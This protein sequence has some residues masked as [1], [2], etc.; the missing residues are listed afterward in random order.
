MS[1]SRQTSN[2]KKGTN[3]AKN[4]ASDIDAQY[5]FQINQWLFEPLG[6]WPHART[7]IIDKMFRAMRIFACLFL[8]AFVT[9]PGFFLFLQVRG[10]AALTGPFILYVM[11]SFKYV[12]LILGQRDFLNCLETIFAD[13]H[14]LNSTNERNIMIVS[15]KYGRMATVICATCMYSAWIL[16]AGIFPRISGITVTADNETIRTFAFPGYYKFF[17]PQKSPAYEIIYYL[18]CCCAF[19]MLSI[20]C[21]TCSLAVAFVM[22]ACGQLEITITWLKGL[23]A[24]T[25]DGEDSNIRLSMIVQHHVKTLRC[26][27]D[28]ISND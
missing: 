11:S 5:A 24:K 19:V 27:N 12:L 8:L 26:K 21:A 2:M 20:T 1:G 16:Y 4:V 3:E 15:A 18:H 22:H 25:G 23:V 10:V 9:I 13:W 14:K 7:S 6:L 28:R 17:D